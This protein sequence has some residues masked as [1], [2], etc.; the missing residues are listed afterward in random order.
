[1]LKA[2]SHSNG[3]EN[4]FDWLKCST[5]NMPTFIQP[6]EGGIFNVL[7]F[8]EACVTGTFPVKHTHLCKGKTQINIPCPNF[9]HLLKLNLIVH[10]IFGHFGFLVLSVSDVRPPATGFSAIFADSEN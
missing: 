10:G 4:T 8:I 7:L 1:M 5:Q 2:E 6:I 3:K 9:L